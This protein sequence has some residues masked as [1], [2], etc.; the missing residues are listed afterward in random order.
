MSTYRNGNQTRERI[1]TVSADY[2][3]NN[4]HRGITMD[5]LAALIG[6]SK[7]TIYVYFPTKVA[8]LEAVMQRKFEDIFTTLDSVRK[9]H[10]AN[11]IECFLAVLERWQELLSYVQPV[12]W[13]DL[14]LDATSFFESTATKRKRIIHEIFGRIIRDGITNRDFRDDINPEMV[15]DIMLAS[16]EGIIRSGK[17]AEY[18]I[19]PKELLLML[20][21]LVIEGSLTNAGR[22]KWEKSDSHAKK[23]MNTGIA[24]S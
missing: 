8:I 24:L 15:A 12:F 14:Q 2:F 10:E 16:I 4:G 7:K 5:E 18:K 23:R 6:V 13:R 1:V 22:E 9:A 3:F 17:C 21:R 20:V 11:S 19:S